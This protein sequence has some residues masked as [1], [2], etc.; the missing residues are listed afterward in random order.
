MDTEGCD[1]ILT[2]AIEG[3]ESL[4]S[5]FQLASKNS[6]WR[7]VMKSF[8]ANQNH[9]WIHLSQLKDNEGRRFNNIAI[10]QS[11][12]SHNNPVGIYGQHRI[13]VNSDILNKS[14]NIG[15]DPTF[16][17]MSLVHEG[18]HARM[19]E[20]YRQDGYSFSKYPGYHDFIIIRADK[21]GHHNQMGTFNRE[22]LVEAMKEFDNQIIDSG[23][24][25]PEYHTEDWYQAMSWY[26]LRNTRAWNDF[27]MNNSDKANYYSILINEQIKRNENGVNEE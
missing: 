16:L 9:V 4:N 2:K 5:F 17:F 11:N 22:I 15:I 7:N 24:T 27:K 21:G 26:G 13:I 1:V 12:L 6:V 3:N 20:R 23:G 14:G 25:I 18:D 19:Y 8:Y 10:T